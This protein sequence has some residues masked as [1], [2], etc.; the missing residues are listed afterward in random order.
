M[1]SSHSLSQYVTLLP[2]YMLLPERD[3]KNQ[4]SGQIASCTLVCRIPKTDRDV[5]LVREEIAR[6]HQR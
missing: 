1:A 4:R 3:T 5:S 2:Y 6:R